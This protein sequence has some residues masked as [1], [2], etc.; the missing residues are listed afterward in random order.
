VIVV[1][2]V[3]AGVL[4]GLIP[5]ARASETLASESNKLTVEYVTGAVVNT[6]ATAAVALNLV[7]D[8]LSSGLHTYYRLTIIGM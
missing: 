4:W 2:S 3:A 1:V 5:A 8:F 7:H 6:I